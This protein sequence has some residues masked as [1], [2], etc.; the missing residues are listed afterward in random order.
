MTNLVNRTKG[1]GSGQFVITHVHVRDLENHDTLTVTAGGVLRMEISARAVSDIRRPNIGFAVN[2]PDG[3]LIFS[4]SA[5]NLGVRLADLA[6]G[7]TCRVIFEFEAALAP[8]AYPLTVIAADNHEAVTGDSGA[9]HDTRERLAI[10]KVAAGS[11]TPAFD[12]VGWLGLC[13]SEDR[14]LN[15]IGLTPSNSDY[16][17]R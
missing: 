12:G 5:L 17:D 13:V 7:E 11:I 6:P 2:K 10:L 8:G 14:V 9:H 16:N 3:E 15:K 4:I 1:F